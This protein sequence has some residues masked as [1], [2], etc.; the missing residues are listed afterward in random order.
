MTEIGVSPNSWKALATILN[1]IRRRFQAINLETI[2]LFL[3]RQNATRMTKVK[4]SMHLNQ[5]GICLLHVRVSYHHFLSVQAEKRC[6]VAYQNMIQRNA[7]DPMGHLAVFRHHTKEMQRYGM[8][9]VQ[10]APPVVLI[11]LHVNLC[12]ARESKPL[13]VSV[14]HS[15]F[16]IYCDG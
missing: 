7:A 12:S 11:A 15:Q 16:S 1:S 9:S 3:G 6:I 13:N 4:T 14:V 5:A 8:R 2:K 10:T